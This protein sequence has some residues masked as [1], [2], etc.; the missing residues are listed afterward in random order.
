MTVRIFTI[1]RM[2][3]AACLALALSLALPAYTCAGYIAPDGS[4]VTQL[5][6]GADSSRYHPTRIKHYPLQRHSPTSSPYW[7]AS[8]PLWY[9]LLAFLW[10]VPV[11]GARALR[12]RSRTAVALRWTE[13]PLAI[14]SGVAIWMQASVGRPASGTYVALTANTALLIAWALELSPRYVRRT[15]RLPH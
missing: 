9:T 3:G 7:P 5:P 14:A 4:L 12:P 2:R 15:P 10:W 8:S 13:P 11:L 1:G 6:H